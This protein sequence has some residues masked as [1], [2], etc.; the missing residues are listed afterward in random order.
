MTDQRLHVRVC[1]D[2]E[3]AVVEAHGEIDVTTAPRLNTILRAVAHRPDSYV[4]LDL[5]FTTSIGNEGIL[6]L[7]AAHRA[8]PCL[9]A[10]FEVQVVAGSQ[11]E[12]ML[13]QAAVHRHFSVVVWDRSVAPHSL[14]IDDC[15]GGSV[16]LRVP[17]DVFQVSRVRRLTE[18]VLLLRDVDDPWICDFVTAVGEAVANAVT[19]GSPCGCMGYVIFSL[20]P[21]PDRIV[22]EVRDFG[23]GIEGWTGH[24]EMPPPMSIRGRGMGMM[25]LLVDDLQVSTGAT[26]TRVRLQKCLSGAFAS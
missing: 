24:P 9:P 12:A 10:A 5:R 19:H 4:V 13:R 16:E 14:G 22:A 18:Q 21:E 26:G 15:T 25:Q 8:Q 17:A 11:P 23:R 20:K 6:A 3:R 1:G 2:D 7:L